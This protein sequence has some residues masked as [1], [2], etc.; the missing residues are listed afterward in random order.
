M[1]GGDT[2]LN[3]SNR[4]STKVGALSDIELETCRECGNPVKVIT[5]IEDPVVIEKILTHLQE[6]I[7]TAPTVLWP[8]SRAPPADLFV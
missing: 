5:C 2:G 1:M 6:T 7:T 3:A 4:C 8:A